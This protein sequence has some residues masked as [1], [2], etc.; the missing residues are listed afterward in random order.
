[1]TALKGAITAL[2]APTPEA[3]KQ[4]EQL[5]ITWQGLVPTLQQIRDKSLAID[6]LRMLIPDIEA[7][8]GVASLTQNFDE[9]V[10]I[11]RSMDNA[12][13]S[14]DRAYKKMEDTPYHEIQMMNKALSKAM[15]DLG[16]FASHGIVPAA[17]ALS[18][19]VSILNKTPAPIKVIAQSMTTLIGATLLWKL[20]LK[21]TIGGLN[22]FAGSVSTAKTALAGLT[23]VMMTN[24]VFAATGLILAAAAAWEQFGNNSLESSK[25]HGEIATTIGE[26]RKEI[27]K[28]V[29]S[30]S[31]LR[32]VLNNTAPDSEKHLQAERELAKILPDANLSLDEQ[33][34]LIAKVG[35]EASENNK[36]LDQFIKTLKEESGQSWALQ[37]EQQAK[38]YIEAGN[39]LDKYKE[40]LLEWYGIGQNSTTII[41]DFWRALNKLSGTY[42]KNIQ[43]G[44]KVRTNLYQ[45]KQA[46]EQLLA[47]A[48]NADIS[49]DE[50][51]NSLNRARVSAEIKDSIISDYQKLTGAINE[52]TTASEKSAETQ[53][54][55][56]DAALEEMQRK[57][58]EYQAEIQKILDEIAGRQMSLTEELREMSRSG[59][60]DYSAWKDLKRE[61]QEYEQLAKRAFQSADF[62]SA[63]LYADKAKEKYKALNQEVKKNDQVVVSAQRALK[64][65]MNGV[66]SSGKL[67]I[68]ALEKQKRAAEAAAEKLDIDSGGKLSKSVEGIADGVDRISDAS[69]AMGDTMVDQINRFGDEA[70]KEFNKINQFLKSQHTM[71][72]QVKTNYPKSLGGPIPYQLGGPIGKI[73]ALAA[74][75]SVGLR[76]ML[77]GGH[78][79]GFG[80]GDRRHV[81]AE[82]GEFMIRKESVR[83]YGIS[84]FH[85]LN[86]MKINR[87]DLK[88]RISRLIQPI[89]VEPVRMQTGG[90]LAAATSHSAPPTY[91]VTF[92]ISNNNTDRMSHVPKIGENKEMARKVLAGLKEL[93]TGSSY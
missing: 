5:G 53:V 60:S 48:R 2:T 45:Q 87:I 80:G 46:Y 9:F 63:V 89:Q 17:N 20:G 79:P 61:A 14:M 7:R 23:K 56:T 81:I 84:L 35:D 40:N 54:A 29:Q 3:K 26:S 65:A 77:R 75:G 64:T 12:T 59:M 76:N 50:L 86:S 90:L 15:T 42:D 6:Q 85:A 88:D 92:N 82:D 83:K 78:F 22:I 91:N 47:S 73:Q 55:V 37:F 43:E 11:L 52:V 44:E 62:D 13:G 93:Y 57:Y 16:G 10:K 67:A 71:T 1:M 30:L 58:K 21:A 19:F 31:K 28:Q 4:F 72:V 33:G 32:E 39:A 25:K 41:H 66:E 51:S 49:V 70:D 69:K 34:R 24:P 27:D 36:K 18:T 68:E 38:A 74:G 8:S